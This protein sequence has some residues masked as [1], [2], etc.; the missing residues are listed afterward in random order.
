MTNSPL[1]LSI[2]QLSQL[3]LPVS[4]SLEF[5]EISFTIDGN[6]MVFDDFYLSSP[7]L[8]LD[9]SG[10]MSLLDWE[11]A[12]RLYPKGTVP[13]LSDLIG[14]MTGTLFAINVKGTLGA[15][16]ASLEALPLLGSP[17]RIS[18]PGSSGSEP[19]ESEVDLDQTG[20]AG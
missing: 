16:E 18:N 12:L 20:D 13:I 7:T 4:D 8:R 17:A 19:D 14:G 9:G 5:A 11:L 10:E 6:R 2:V 15:P 1:T 3:M